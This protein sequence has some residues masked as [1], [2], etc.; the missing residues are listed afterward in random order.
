[1]GISVMEKT[2]KKQ[3]MNTDTDTDTDTTNKMNTDTTN[4]ITKTKKD[5]DI[6]DGKW[7]LLY[8][9]ENYTLIGKPI[10]GVYPNNLTCPECGICCYSCSC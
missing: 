6:K 2:N 8:P 9:L 10:E 4:N 5:S 1:M 7:D 3:K